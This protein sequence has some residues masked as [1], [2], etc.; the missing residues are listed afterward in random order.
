LQVS[1]QCKL[2]F[3]ITYKF[4]YEVELD[5]VPIDICGIVFGSPYLYDRKDIFYR[6]E[7]KYH[8]TRDGIEYI[9]RACHEKN[10]LPLVS[11]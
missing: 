11:T 8:L 2:I 3:A 10:K 6:E 9:V 7:K 5:V 4:I 1:K